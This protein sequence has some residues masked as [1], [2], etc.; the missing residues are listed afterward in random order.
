[1]AEIKKVRTQSDIDAARTLAWEF[2]AFLRERYPEMNAEID[3]YLEAQDFQGQLSD[4][5]TFFN[6]PAGECL[7]ATHADM[8]AGI[9]MLKAGGGSECELNRMYVRPSA[10]GLGLGRRLCAQLIEEAERLGY[11]E[12]RLSALFRH[13]EALPL[14]RS[15]GFVECGPFAGGGTAED[16]RVIFMRRPLNSGTPQ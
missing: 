6:P 14:Y 8:P 15:L 3:D 5:T 2:V 16:Q 7:L 12:I 11:L 9:V 10:R 1:M 4:F 13:H